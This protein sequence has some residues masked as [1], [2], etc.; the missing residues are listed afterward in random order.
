VFQPDA[1][2]K[3][4]LPNPVGSPVSVSMESGLVVLA[5][6]QAVG[7]HSI[8]EYEPMDCEFCRSTLYPAGGSDRESL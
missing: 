5:P 8:K 7:K 6:N 3:D 1:R 2:G 4:Y